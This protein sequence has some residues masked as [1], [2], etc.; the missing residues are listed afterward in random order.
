M[1]CTVQRHSFVTMNINKLP[2][3][4]PATN[5]VKTQ[6]IQEVGNIF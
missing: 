4:N 5:K 1:E 3:L 6:W 2:F